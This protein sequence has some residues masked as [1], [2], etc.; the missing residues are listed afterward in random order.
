MSKI[1]RFVSLVLVFSL[2]SVVLA[3][4]GSSNP[5]LGKWESTDGSGETIEFFKDDTFVMESSIGLNISGTYSI[6]DS[7]K[8]K[9]DMEGL[10]GLNGP[11]I[12]TLSNKG[13]TLT[14]TLSGVDFEYEKAE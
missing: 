13:K 10:W 9:L 5:V 7:D 12:A 6:E 11:I 14:L 8:I 1:R 4:C 2:I 3:A